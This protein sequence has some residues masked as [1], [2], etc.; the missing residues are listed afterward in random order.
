MATPDNP[1]LETGANEITP[2]GSEA[3]PI[4]P[5]AEPSVTQADQAPG[6]EATKLDDP[7]K[8]DKDSGTVEGSDSDDDNEE[9]HYL[10]LDGE[11]HS[12]DDVRKWKNGS[13]MQSDY[14]K[15]T[16]EHAQFAKKERAEIASD[17]EN[18]LKS[19][20]EVSDMRDQ[21]AALV[22]EDENIDWVELKE[23]N[24]EEYVELK[25]KADKR[26]ELLE[27]VKA[28]RKTPANDP[29]LI[30]SEQAKL[31]KANPDW[32]DENNVIQEQFT[33]D[34]VMI[35]DYAS[36]AGFTPEEFSQMSYAHHQITLLK[37]AKFDEL[38]QKGQ[39]L[40]AKR[41]KV[42][43][44]TKPKARQTGGQ[45]KTAGEIFFPNVK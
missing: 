22:M 3:E 36:K 12:L 16:T 24:L 18:L 21:L 33:K 2:T 45:T 30:Q 40:K 14:T 39:E 13:M 26:K 28:E 34:T 19:Q 25:E 41:I 31:F 1:A 23:N 20:S 29:A 17:R 10:E 7:P 44:V 9:V 37:A 6:Q 8:P 42:P 4:K 35:A 11:E 5:T 32:L 27:K 43:L 15:K 38:Q